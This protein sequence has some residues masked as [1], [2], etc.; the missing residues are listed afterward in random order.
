M[1]FCQSAGKHAAVAAGSTVAATEI[2]SNKCGERKRNGWGGRGEERKKRG[3]KGEERI[4][5]KGGRGGEIG[6]E[7]ESRRCRDG[8]S[9]DE[10]GLSVDCHHR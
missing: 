2:D 3:A 7:K 6:G 9:S 5:E 4:K 1:T 10:P 8:M